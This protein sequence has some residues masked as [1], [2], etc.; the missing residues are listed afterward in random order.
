MM[1]EKLKICWLLTDLDRLWFDLTGFAG[2]KL[3]YFVEHGTGALQEYPTP[4]LFLL[5][6]QVLVDRNARGTQL[7]CACHKHYL[8]K[9]SC[10]V[11]LLAFPGS[12]K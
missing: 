7:L 8:Y 12:L 9:Q 1:I 6:V 3:K 11:P 10:H 4:W 2:L 5:F